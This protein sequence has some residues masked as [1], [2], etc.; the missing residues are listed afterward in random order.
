MGF[1]VSLGECIIQTPSLPLIGFTDLGYSGIPL[2][3]LLTLPYVM[4]Y[5]T[6]PETSLD[7]GC[8]A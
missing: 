3:A 2:T 8:C 1:H 5:V 7:C 4:V 6:P